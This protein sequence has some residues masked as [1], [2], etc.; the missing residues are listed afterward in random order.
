VNITLTVAYF[1]FELTAVESETTQVVEVD[2][3]SCNVGEAIGIRITTPKQRTYEHSIQ[4]KL[5]D[6]NNEEKYED[7]IH[8][9][10]MVRALG[11]TMV[12]LCIVSQLV[13]RESTRKFAVREVQILKYAKALEQVV[14]TFFSFII[15]KVP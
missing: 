6:S 5:L 7:T 1:I 8:G 11:E 4:L 3:S 12:K 14:R 13:V 2:E 9:L 15:E 10:R